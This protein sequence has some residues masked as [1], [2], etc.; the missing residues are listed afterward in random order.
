M[1][2]LALVVFGL[3]SYQSIG[4]N[5]FP[6]VD[7]PMVT[8]TVMN[9]GMAPETMDREVAELVEE[10][11]GTISGIKTLRSQS[12]EGITQVF[13]EFELEENVDVKTQEVR[14]KVSLIRQ[15]L[16]SEIEEPTVEKLDLDSAP[17]MSILVAGQKSITQLTRTADERIKPMIETIRG[18][19]NVQMVGDRDR[20]VRIWLRADDLR[21]YSLTA[22][23]VIDSLRSENLEPPGGRVETGSRE[24]IVKTRG[25]IQKVADFEQVIVK[26]REQNPIRLADVAYVEDGMEDCRSIARLNGQRAVCLQVRPQAG[27]NMVAVADMVKGELDGIRNFL[28][29]DDITLT[30]AQDNSE[31]VNMSISEAEGELLRGA[32]LAVAVIFFF[33]RSLRGSFV[34]TC[35]IPATIIGTYAFMYMM[36]FT[37]NMMTMLALT[38]SVGMIVD[39][40]IVVLENTF[41][42]MEEG[43]GRM[44]AAFLAMQE[45]GFAVIVT[46]LAIA[47]VFVPVAF[48][49]GI[50]GKFFFEFGLSVTAAVVISTII[51]VTLSPMLCGRTLKLSKKHGRFFNI[52][53]NGLRAVE[54]FY[55]FLLERSL[56]LRWLV[57]VLAIGFFASSLFIAGFIGS[58]FIPQADE[59][60]F[61]I[62]VEAPIGTSIDASDHLLAE[63]ERR[64]ATLPGV[65]DIFTTIGAGVEEQVHKATVLVKLL[66]KAE[67]TESQFE[68]MDQARAVLADL[69]QLKLSVEIVPRVSASGYSVA[70]FQYYIGGTDLNEIVAFSEKMKHELAETGLVIDVLSSWNSGKPELE[71]SPNREKATLMG[72]ST[73]DVANAIYTL[74]GGTDITTFEENGES[75]DVRVRLAEED[76]DRI[77]SV[78][79]VPV[80]TNSG[81]LVEIRNVVDAKEQL[82]PVQIDRRD[83]MRQVTLMANIAPGAVLGDAMT[84][85]REIEKKIGV[86]ASLSTGFTGEA[87]DMEE[88]FRYIFISMFL[89]VL[90]IYMVLAA[91]FESLI[92]PLTIMITLPLSITGALGGLFLTGAT[93]SIF[94][95]IGM[96]M[97]MGLVTKNAIL[98]IDYT[99]QLREKGVER[100]DAIR[101][102]G[103]VRLRPILMTALSTIAGMLPAAMGLGEGAETRAPMGICIVGGMLTSTILTLVVIPVVYTILDDLSSFSKRLFGFA[104]TGETLLQETLADITNKHETAPAA[105]S[106]TPTLCPETT[107]LRLEQDTIRLDSHDL[108]KTRH[109][110][111]ARTADQVR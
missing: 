54:R 62:Q 43:H 50:V 26:Q 89:A 77:A 81:E 13:V 61:N 100:N 63:I 53:E 30:I 27:T 86:P 38:I 71:I 110:S 33:L 22:Q 101:R 78:L 76:R 20:E 34:A 95:L 18:V 21:A 19:G 106:V 68:L 107:I 16:P 4:V 39:D 72:I 99:N 90:L 12:L 37:V 17:I 94:S 25:K 88:S 31:F 7:I 104:P 36:G 44:K 45:I 42:H 108:E 91:Q 74:V 3:I 23:D 48:M 80:R 11:V 65:T 60:Q 75:F 64:V 46:S 9:P 51:A 84:K 56:R 57:V 14:D 66:P 83:R 15:D 32:I 35:T 2:V 96:I 29:K 98:L 87:Q 79:S 111:K 5:M 73:E 52:I 67:R 58:E 69:S 92:H 24:I 93:I 41:R 103:P 85:A 1:G 105:A 49:K 55:G 59:N 82:G 97:L 10:S 28:A 8:V 47:A 6:K 102:A 40:S 70:P 109:Q